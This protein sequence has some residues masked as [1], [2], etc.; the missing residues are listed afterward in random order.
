MSRSSA[1]TYEHRRE[2][3]TFADL[4][5]AAQLNPFHL[6]RIF[7]QQVGLPPSASRR[8]L[9]VCAAQRRTAYSGRIVNLALCGLFGECR[10]DVSASCRRRQVRGAAG[11]ATSS[12]ASHGA[13]ATAVGV[14]PAIALTSRWRWD[15]ST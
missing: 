9:P 6:P 2:D 7:R 4:A 11:H 5:E 15:W 14:T 13:V 1:T 3:F 8:A 12:I 10:P